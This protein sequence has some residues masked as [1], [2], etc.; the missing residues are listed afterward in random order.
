VPASRLLQSKGKQ[1]GDS[2]KLIFRG[3]PLVLGRN[4]SCDKILD[5]SMISGRHARLWRDGSR[6][7]IEDLGS[8]NG[9]FVNGERV[10]LSA[11]VKAR[12]I[13]GMGS[14]LMEL[15]VAS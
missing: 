11:E 9:T 12:D 13:I 7:M 10:H 4:S 6:I 14:L 8:T 15:E 1:A 2:R 3:Q 5:F